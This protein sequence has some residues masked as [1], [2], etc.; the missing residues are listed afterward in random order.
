MNDAWR[1][2]AFHMHTFTL[3]WTTASKTRHSISGGGVSEKGKGKSS[4]LWYGDRQTG[5]SRESREM[6]H[7]SHR[8]Q[9]PGAHV[10]QPCGRSAFSS[11]SC[12]HQDSVRAAVRCEHGLRVGSGR[13]CRPHKGKGER[14]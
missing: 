7:S 6:W 11:V 14:V 3:R 13:E 5:Q 12:T 4:R 9:A 1:V 2:A 10:A 8:R